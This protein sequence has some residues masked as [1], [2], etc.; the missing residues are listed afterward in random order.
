MK[1]SKLSVDQIAHALCQAECAPTSPVAP[2]ARLHAS[3]VIGWPRQFGVVAPRLA[4]SSSS[5]S[6]DSGIAPDD[7]AE[8]SAASFEG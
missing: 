1:Q 6:S 7:P 4:R 2:S 8:T 3:V 5:W